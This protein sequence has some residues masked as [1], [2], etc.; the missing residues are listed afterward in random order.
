[1]V[2]RV[3]ISLLLIASVLVMWPTGVSAR[4]IPVKGMRINDSTTISRVTGNCQCNWEWFTVGLKPGTLTVSA[5][6]KSCAGMMAPACGM[7][8]DL[9]RGNAMLTR[10]QSGCYGSKSHC[11]QP[12]D[13]TYRISRQGVYYLMVHGAGAQEVTYAMRVRGN[14]YRLACWAS[15]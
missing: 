9:I 6:I 5:T 8:I 15:C 4:G 10:A 11:N 3:V 14:I 13:L 1:M 7:Y 2:R 12:L